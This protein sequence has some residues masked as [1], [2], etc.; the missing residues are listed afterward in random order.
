M[1]KRILV[2]AAPGAGKGTQGKRLAERLGVA[3]LAAGD[4]LREQQST[5]GHPTRS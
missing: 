5:Y 3:H 2:L 4:L 1:P